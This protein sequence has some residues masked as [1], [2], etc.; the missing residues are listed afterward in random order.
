MSFG[1]NKYNYKEPLMR[2]MQKDFLEKMHAIVDMIL[3]FMFI[4]EQVLTFVAKNQHSLSHSRA[5]QAVPD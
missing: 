5:N 1:T 2:P 3:M 4:Q